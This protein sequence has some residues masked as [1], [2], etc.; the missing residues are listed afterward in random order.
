MEASSPCMP[1]GKFAN[2]IVA[3]V[4][5][6]M[7]KAEAALELSTDLAARSNQVERRW[8]SAQEILDLA[9]SFSFSRFSPE[10]FSTFVVL[11]CHYDIDSDMAPLVMKIAA[12]CERE[13]P[14]LDYIV[15]CAESGLLGV[16]HK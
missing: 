6:G 5:T 8:S 4:K 14:T 16:S 13:R 10:A 7:S 1:A 3:K 9:Y 11:A 2:T 12:S 15:I